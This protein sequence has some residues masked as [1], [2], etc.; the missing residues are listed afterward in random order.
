MKTL[1]S[2][3]FSRFGKAHEQVPALICDT[4]ACRILGAATIW[5]GWF[6]LSEQNNPTKCLGIKSE[7]PHLNFTT[8]PIISAFVS[9]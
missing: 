6:A 3:A 8:P 4:Y 5:G 9:K 7:I 1:G 2:G